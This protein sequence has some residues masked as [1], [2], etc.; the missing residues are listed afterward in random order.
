MK[1][2]RV[3]RGILD[4]F[5]HSEITARKFLHYAR[6]GV[7]ITEDIEDHL[8]AKMSA[9]GDHDT[10]E[11][12]LAKQNHND[13]VAAVGW[14]RNALATDTEGAY[15]LTQIRRQLRNS[16]CDLYAFGDLVDSADGQHQTPTL[17][18]LKYSSDEDSSAW[19]SPAASADTRK[20]AGSRI[21]SFP[22]E[23]RGFLVVPR[24]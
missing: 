3:R 6:L 4:T 17:E 20:L 9:V 2:E 13:H 10:P 24:P 22:R 15:I 16:V 11:I 19:R 21:E 5:Q 1:E 12:S 18:K 8:V 14:R 7:L 23:Q